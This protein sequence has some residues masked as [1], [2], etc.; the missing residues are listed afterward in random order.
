M[1]GSQGVLSRHMFSLRLGFGIWVPV[2]EGETGEM[3]R[4][5]LAFRSYSAQLQDFI[6]QWS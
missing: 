4:R 3:V 6:L 5:W 1:A 2:A